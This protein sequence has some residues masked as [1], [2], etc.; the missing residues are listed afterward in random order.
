MK[1]KKNRRLFLK[2][3]TLSGLG[4]SVLPGITISKNSV[5]NNGMAHTI[6]NNSDGASLHTFNGP[7]SGDYL[8]RLAFP[9]GGIGAGMFCLEG[10]GAISHMSV[11]NRPQMFN[12]PEMFAAISVKGVT[13]GAKIIE[14]PVPEWKIFG[15]RGTG[16]GAAMTTY[17]LPRFRN[18]VFQTA[19]PTGIISLKDE[20]IPLEAEIK[21]WS[22]FIPG[23]ADNSSLPVGALEYH[24]TN[25]SKTKTE[26]VFS[27]NAGNFMVANDK[28]GAIKKME[29]GFVLS[30][31]GTPE[32]P[33]LQ[34]D[35]AIFTDDKNAVVDYCW[36]RGGWW[37][38][39]TMIWNTIRDAEIKNNPPVNSDAP[40]ASVF[41]PFTLQPGEK[42]TI[43]ILMSWYI[44]FSD[45]HIGEINKD[46]EECASPGCCKTSDELGDN[47]DTQEINYRPWYSSRFKNVGEVSAYW[48]QAY[49]TLQEKTNLF[50]KAFYASTLPPEVMEAIAA[51]LSILKT[52]TVMRQ[53]DGRLWNFEGCGDE[54]GCCHGSCTHVWNY[55]QAIP[56]LFPSLERTLRHTEFCESQNAE[57]H[58]N[59]RSNTPIRP[60][61]HTFYAAADGQ[62][63][64]I[65]KVY[66]EW[67]ISGDNEWMK[68]LFPLVK[69]SMDYCIRTWDPR[70]K[71]IVE[72]PHHNT[73]D[74][75]FWGPDGMCTGF[76][77]G[78][79]DAFCKMGK[80]MKVN[81]SSYQKLYQKGRMYMESELY[82]GEYFFQ[83]IQYKGLNAPDPIAVAKKTFGGEYS[84]EAIALLEKEGPKY[85][86]GKG[87]L[88][89]GILGGWIA[90]MCG[91]ENP[92]DN[93]KVKSHLLSVHKY[94][95]KKNLSEHANPQRPAYAIGEEG[96]LL[97]CT[98][99]KG[100]KLSL[101]FVY[102]DEVWTGIE[103]QV[104]SHLML[105][106][107]VEEGLEI[108]RT[109]RDRYSGKTRNPFNEYECG[110][111]YGRA[112]S[113][114]GL[115]QGL[116]GIRFDAVDRKLYVDSK[117]G[118]FTSFL[119]TGSG[120]G[121]VHL[122]NGKV[123]VEVLYGSIPVKTVVISGKET[124]LSV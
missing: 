82:D 63:G 71:G 60:A 86:Y 53:Y 20:D 91:L 1:A 57:G 5:A 10:C 97:L 55:A 106:G 18:T 15:R 73:Y 56:H 93:N 26:A 64:G 108:V 35:F 85:Q 118:D 70:G 13:N 47:I 96:G 25:I 62:L 94:N 36:F 48:L 6:R 7:Y 113:S 34:G 88:S 72:E 105:M 78:A 19:F 114:Y 45:M 58:Q 61:T 98:W 89:D 22:P 3:I 50:T 101:P 40:G 38:P 54:G 9:I 4:I 99:P 46:K 32:K 59:F 111:W 92:V 39:L 123:S 119:A 14:G 121:N 80:F 75:E 21:G 83:Q 52:P 117:V 76:Y 37:D 68:K 42:K 100:G 116:T 27:Y 77:L 124:V 81:I 109:C 79:L 112:L 122:K 67:R 49:D 28:K 41:V 2:N 120:F 16:N 65:M 66:R 84:E 24:F 44:P 107:S 87:C 23:D 31:D 74:I 102:S 17:G 69:Q 90:M 12:E 43:R 51:N 95:L 115:L 33:H 29:N 8:R 110:S 103:Y 11:R 104:A 30:Q